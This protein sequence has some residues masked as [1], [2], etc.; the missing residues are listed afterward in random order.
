MQSAIQSQGDALNLD[1]NFREGLKFIAVS[2]L[3]TGNSIVAGNYGEGGG[4]G[5]RVTKSNDAGT[6]GT[7]PTVRTPTSGMWLKA[8]R[9]YQATVRARKVSGTAG[10]LLR[11]I[12]TG[13]NATLAVKQV[14]AT[15]TTNFVD[16]SLD[17]APT[18]DVFA[19]FG[20]WMYQTLGLLI[21]LLFAW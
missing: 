17:Y 1:P 3:A 6:S 10:L 5:L 21:I 2:E 16:F 11:W 12:R 18:S 13:D 7:N 14:T 4:T 20:V 15:D 19:W 9:T 8:G